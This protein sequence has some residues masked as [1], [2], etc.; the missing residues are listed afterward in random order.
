MKM[1]CPKCNKEAPWVENK[2]RYGRNFGKSY[3][4]YY[5]KDCD[6][7]VG[8]HNNSQRPLGTMADKETMKWRKNA[9][10]VVDELWKENGYK[11]GAVYARLQDA[12]GEVIHIG[13]SN[14]ERCKEIIKTVP[15]IFQKKNIN[16]LF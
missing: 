5:C 1:I 8:C 14:I 3:M 7:Y 12:F 16:K 6:T 11:R 2:A 9:H 13:E 15:L 4:C 10:E